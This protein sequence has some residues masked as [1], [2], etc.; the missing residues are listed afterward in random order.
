MGDHGLQF[1]WQE[2]Y[3]AFSVS[4]SNL[5]KVKKYIANQAE[6][7]RKMTFETEFVDLLQ[8]YGIEFD[9]KYVFRQVSPPTGLVFLL[10]L[11]RPSG[12]G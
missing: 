5:G 1:G 8:K 7:H 10:P 12:L 9:P 3:G 4:A 6:H 11:P 2:G